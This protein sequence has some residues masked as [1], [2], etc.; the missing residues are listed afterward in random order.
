LGRLRRRLQASRRSSDKY[1]VPLTN[2]RASLQSS[3][4]KAVSNIY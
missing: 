4:D 2:S 3:L 1:V